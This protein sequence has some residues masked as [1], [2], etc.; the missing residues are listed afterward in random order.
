MLKRGMKEAILTDYSEYDADGN[1][2]TVTLTLDERL[3]PAANAQ[4]LYKRYNKKYKPQHR[5]IYPKSLTIQG[6]ALKVIKDI[7]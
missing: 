1:P 2:A 3:S 7:N 5:D 4:R 6:I